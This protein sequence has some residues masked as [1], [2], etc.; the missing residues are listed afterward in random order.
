MTRE[1]GLSEILKTL[2]NHEQRICSL[3]G[4]KQPQKISGAKTWYRPG[5]TS[6]KIV[7]L[8]GEGFFQDP[9][10][11]SEIIAKLK[12][13]DIHLKASDLTLPLRNVVRKGLLEK[14]KKKSDGSSSK[15]W[16][17]VKV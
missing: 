7:N 13:R 5:S 6:E 10:S 3:E 14:T 12:T 2:E 17:Y 8:I 11:I 15:P 1:K 4:K 9:R 16:L